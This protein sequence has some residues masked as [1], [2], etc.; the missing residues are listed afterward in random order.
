MADR[1]RASDAEREEY[2]LI[3]RAAMTEGRLTLEEGEER[4]GQVYAAKYRDEL[5]PLTADDTPEAKAERRRDSRHHLGRHAGRIGAIALVLIGIWVISG[6]HFFWPA[7]PLIF[8][9]IGFAKHAGYRRWAS[10]H[11]GQEPHWRRNRHWGR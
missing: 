8:L 7:F 1:L 3:L 2:A 5:P 6:A 9:A 11:P 4:L 10:E